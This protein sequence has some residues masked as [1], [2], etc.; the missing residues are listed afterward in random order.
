MTVSLDEG[1][2][3]W[4]V[5]CEAFV[6]EELAENAPGQLGAHGWNRDIMY[7]NCDFESYQSNSGP[8]VMNFAYEIISWIAIDQA[9]SC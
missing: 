3:G 6:R 2:F 5:K 7:R 4:A 8:K 9:W 1:G